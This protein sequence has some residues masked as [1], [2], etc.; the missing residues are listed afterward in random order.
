M[1]DIEP[2]QN[3]CD[4]YRLDTYSCFKS[5]L[6]KLGSFFGLASIAARTLRSGDSSSNLAML[7][8]T[9]WA[10]SPS[11]MIHYLHCASESE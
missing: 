9:T 6:E 5:V 4:L 7:T 2:I 1:Q 11:Q 3:S 8:G 10:L